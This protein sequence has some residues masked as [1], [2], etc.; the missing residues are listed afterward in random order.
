MQ[1]LR[2]GNAALDAL[3]QQA[4]A[5]GYVFAN[6]LTRSYSSGESATELI[7]LRVLDR[8]NAKDVEVFLLYPQA[9][10][11]VGLA[12]DSAGVTDLRGNALAA[13]HAWQFR[14]GGT[15][16][17][18]GALYVPAVQKQRLQNQLPGSPTASGKLI[19][20]ERRLAY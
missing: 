19:P 14:V 5:G 11:A 3:W 4:E 12:V 10:G 2:S 15:L 7:F 16:A 6:A 18:G 1:A 8:Q 20:G 13:D 9:D 17:P